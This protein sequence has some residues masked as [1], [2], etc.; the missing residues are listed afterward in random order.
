MAQYR[1]LR[2]T[3]PTAR[4]HSLAGRIAPFT[5][6][7][8]ERRGNELPERGLGCVAVLVEEA[9]QLEIKQR[10]NDLAAAETLEAQGVADG[11]VGLQK[12]F[13]KRPGRADGW[14]SAV[15]ETVL[16]TRAL[17]AATLQRKGQRCA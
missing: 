17:P 10:E 12:R 2:S 6:I 14:R 8:L 16:Q 11:G 15:L 5:A 3:C 9:D 13:A 1:C 7:D 4:A